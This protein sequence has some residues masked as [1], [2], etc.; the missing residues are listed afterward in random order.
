MKIFVIFL[1]SMRGKERAGYRR[2]VLYNFAAPG[3]RGLPDGYGYTRLEIG[4]AVAGKSWLFA[5]FV[6][7][8]I[9]WFVDSCIKYTDARVFKG[10]KPQQKQLCDMHVLCAQLKLT[11][12]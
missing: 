7:A 1:K 11:R 9:L 4:S 12:R 10:S 2:H 5:R 3:N 8:L 6:N